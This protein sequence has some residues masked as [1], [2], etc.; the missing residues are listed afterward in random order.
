MATASPE[1]IRPLSPSIAALRSKHNQ[2]PYR[3]LFAVCPS[4]RPRSVTR[5]RCAGSPRPALAPPLRR[6]FH[7]TPLAPTSRTDPAGPPCAAAPD[8]GDLVLSPRII[9]ARPPRPPAP[10]RAVSRPTRARRL[11]RAR[12]PGGAGHAQQPP[13]R[14]VAFPCAAARL[15]LRGQEPPY[16]RPIRTTP[17][18]TCY[19]TRVLSC[20]AHCAPNH[21]HLAA[22]PSPRPSALAVEDV[23]VHA[24][25]G[26]ARVAV[27]VLLRSHPVAQF[28]GRIPH[29]PSALIHHTRTSTTTP[30]PSVS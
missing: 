11:G 8:D 5:A 29:R 1:H 27:L 14:C 28:Q 26:V 4:A 16:R 7:R 10:A 6:S 18:Q 20:C 12:A 9:I 17:H 19:R 30:P 23:T 15:P 25:A 2:P 22:G 21:I 24:D 3:A 13:D